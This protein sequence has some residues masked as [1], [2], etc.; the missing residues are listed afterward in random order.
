MNTI[1]TSSATGHSSSEVAATFGAGALA[2]F[3]P[4]P[5][6]EWIAAPAFPQESPFLR[7][8]LP[9]VGHTSRRL[10]AGAHFSSGEKFLFGLVAGL[11]VLAVQHGLSTMLD[12]VQHWAQFNAGIERLVN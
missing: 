1:L 7:S 5:A 8:R 2:A 10:V 3:P 4:R 12:L 9:R 6:A 11:S